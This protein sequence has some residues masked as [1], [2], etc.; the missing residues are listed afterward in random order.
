MGRVALT[1]CCDC[2][3]SQ[4]V[5]RGL[6]SRQPELLQIEAAL[7]LSWVLQSSKRWPAFGCSPLGEPELLLPLRVTHPDHGGFSCLSQ[8]SELWL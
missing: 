1:P 7:F 8:E 6:E 2:L 4:A 3:A 5:L